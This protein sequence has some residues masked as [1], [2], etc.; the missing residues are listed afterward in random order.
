SDEDTLGHYVVVPSQTAPLGTTW[1]DEA[2]GEADGG[3]MELD[4][5]EESAAAA[6]VS[7]NNGSW[8]QEPPS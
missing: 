5:G 4:L 1:T 2:T 3:Q 8:A 6:A 7:F